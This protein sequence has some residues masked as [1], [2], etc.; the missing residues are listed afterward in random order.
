MLKYINHKIKE[1]VCR[2]LCPNCEEE[3]QYFCVRHVLSASKTKDELETIDTSVNENYLNRKPGVQQCPF[4]QCFCERNKNSTFL[5]KNWVRCLMCSKNEGRNVEYCW[6]CLK[7]WRGDKRGCGNAGCDGKDSR[8]KYLSSCET[9]TIGLVAGVPSVRACDECGALINHAD[10]C[11]HMKCRC[12]YEFCFVCLKPKNRQ[13][14]SFPCGS[15]N[16]PC[17]VAPRQTS[18]KEIF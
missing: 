4:C 10:K 6:S 14:C 13:S 5:N 17:N 1:G 11:K 9:K 15:Y 7:P 18:V 2:F 8:I 3:W 12:G 16:T